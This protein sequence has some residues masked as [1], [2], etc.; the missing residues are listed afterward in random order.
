MD[1]R[2][3]GED[4]LAIQR[5]ARLAAAVAA[6]FS[7]AVLA[8]SLAACA[9][10]GDDGTPRAGVAP[11]AASAVDAAVTNGATTFQLR[12][13]VAIM[14]DTPSRDARLAAASRDAQK[15][16]GQPAPPK[17]RLDPDATPDYYG[18]ANWTNSPRIRKFVDRL[19]GVG[20]AAANDLGQYIPV[21]V[22]DT[23]T[24]PGSDYY[25]IAVRE[26]SEK[27]HSD[28]PPTRLRGYVQLNA[29]TDRSGRNTLQPAPIHYFGPLIRAQRG[30]PG[31]R[32]VRQPAAG[33]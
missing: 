26:Y 3:V 11:S 2:A 24:Y 18:I 14:A 6:L 13:L 15:A 31:A 10:G 1:E 33:R 20:V 22:P 17:P 16:G 19:P 25:E 30:R 8:A 12:D 32:Q 5:A 28:L 9:G 4:D 23:V 27:L 7:T 21:A 29:G